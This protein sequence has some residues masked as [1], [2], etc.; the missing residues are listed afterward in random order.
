[1]VLF[2]GHAF[3]SV[4]CPV[5]P[6]VCVCLCLCQYFFLSLC[7]SFSACV[8]VFLCGY[9]SLPLSVSLGVCVLSD[10]SSWHKW[11]AVHR[12]WRWTN[13][14]KRIV[15]RGAKIYLRIQSWL[16]GCNRNPTF[17][18]VNNQ[19]L[20]VSIVRPDVGSL[21]VCVLVCGLV[22]HWGL[23]KKKNLMVVVMD[24]HGIFAPSEY[25]RCPSAS[26]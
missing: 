19:K 3:Q 9:V 5:C 10:A 15:L 4:F 23:V 8:C 6:C 25:I 20:K 12:Y 2:L 11:T 24:A 26:R 13:D 22:C 1:M 14:M 18:H 7:V 21:S 16:S 17:K